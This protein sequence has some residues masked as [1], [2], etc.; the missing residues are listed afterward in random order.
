MTM[1]R[2]RRRGRLAALSL[3][4]LAGIAQ[5]PARAFDR[6]AEGVSYT[7]HCFGLLL[8]DPDQHVEECNPVF[9][10]QRLD[11]IVE[12]RGGPPLPLMPPPAPPPVVTPPVAPPPVVT[13]PVVDPPPP[14][15]CDIQQ[16]NCG[17]VCGY[18]DNA[19]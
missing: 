17:P 16:T 10:P 15:D 6:V 2:S 1:F 5:T 11:S 13:P 7:L 19:T 18:P 12:M 4:L 14:P 8:S 3:I 9:P